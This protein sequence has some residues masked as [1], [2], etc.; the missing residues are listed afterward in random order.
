MTRKRSTKT[1]TADAA[2]ETAPVWAASGEAPPE[3]ATAVAVQ[4]RSAERF[5][6]CGLQFSRE[7]RFVSRDSLSATDWQRLLAEPHLRVQGVTRTAAPSETDEG[8]PQ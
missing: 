6:R 5:F 3:D 8:V 4:T 1:T 2:N 7:W